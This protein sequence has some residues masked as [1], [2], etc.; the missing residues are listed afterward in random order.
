MMYLELVGVCNRCGLC[1]APEQKGVRWR[2]TNLVGEDLGQPMAT[3][4]SKYSDR[5][6]GMPIELEDP[7]G[8]RIKGTCRKNSPAETVAIMEN[9]VGKGCS[10]TPTARVR[11]DHGSTAKS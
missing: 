6:D 9:G 4:C 8:H 7:N 2:C 3:S 5:Y 1:C 11:R 10:L